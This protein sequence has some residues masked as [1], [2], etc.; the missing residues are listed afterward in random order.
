MTDFTGKICPFCK[1]AF[2]PGD[3]VVVCSACD[4][5]HHK[6]CWVENRG[7][8]TFGCPGTIQAADTAPTS[9]TAGQTPYDNTPP[10]PAPRTVYCTRCGT[11]SPDTAAFCTRCGARLTTAAPPVQQTVPTAPSFTPP[12]GENDTVLLRLVGTKTE[13]YLPRFQTMRQ[14]NKTASWNWPAFLVAPYWMIYR[15]M[16]AY[17]GAALALILV[18]ALLRAPIAM[19]LLLMGYIAS[20][21]FANHIYRRYLEGKAQQAR[22]MAEPF[23][24]QF[25]VKQGGVNTLAAVLSAVGY[26]LLVIL[27]P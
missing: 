18:L 23:R 11:P 27:L 10:S 17:G 22:A 7:C 26:A 1:T 4:M 15:K 21:V 2:R 24:T 9:V 20:G 6:D 19:V 8:T 13:Y 12:G 16:Y 14:Q 25:I 5:P 3:D